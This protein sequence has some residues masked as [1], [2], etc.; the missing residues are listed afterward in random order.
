MFQRPDEDGVVGVELKKDL[1]KVATA[2]LIMNMTR[3][4]P[5]VLPISEKIFFAI[6]Q[7]AKSVFGKHAVKNY[8]PDFRRAFDHF[9]MHAG[10]RAVIEGLAEQL[11]LPKDKSAPN[12]NTLKWYGSIPNA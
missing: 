3:M 8:T 9:C 5:L 7:I 12:A 6:N 2:S 1:L 11:K 4:G 10:G